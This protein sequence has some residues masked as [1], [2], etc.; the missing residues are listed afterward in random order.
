M[1]SLKE[2][3]DIQNHHGFDAWDVET[4]ILSNSTPITKHHNLGTIRE[5]LNIT[6][7]DSNTINYSKLIEI[8]IKKII[9][10]RNIA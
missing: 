5:L 9:E 1:M 2:M 3:E 8:L 10:I 4:L 6:D 7:K